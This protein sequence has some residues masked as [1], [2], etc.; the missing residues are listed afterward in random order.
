MIKSDVKVYSQA[1]VPSRY[2]HRIFST[3]ATV[4]IGDLPR[5][6]SQVELYDYLKRTVGGDFDLVLKRYLRNSLSV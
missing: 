2:S 4:F 3:P 5:D 6:T 1:A